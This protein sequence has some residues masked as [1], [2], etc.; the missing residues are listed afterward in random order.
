MTKVLL[1]D[2][3]EFAA[4]SITA[5]LEQ[6]GLQVSNARSIQE[7]LTL[8]AADKF[9]VLLS[10]LHMSG[11]GLTAVSAMRQTNPGSVTLLLNAFSDAADA[12]HTILL[13]P[14]EIAV[15]PLDLA[16]LVDVIQ[17]RIAR[18]S[19]RNRIVEGVDQILA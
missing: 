13:Q 1:V 3:D 8:I 9:D 14:D 5:V 6:S 11:G 17:S 19:V 7:A 18:G 4:S 10:D 12:T 15:E 2:D 16:A